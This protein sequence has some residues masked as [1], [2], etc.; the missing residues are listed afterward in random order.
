MKPPKRLRTIIDCATAQGWTYD[1]TSE[2]HPRLT[3]PKG[4]PDPQRPGR[5]MYPVTF[6]K[7]PSDRRGDLNSAAAL[8]RCGVVLPSKDGSTKK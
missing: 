2:G 7:T 6:S 4:M 1:E 8:K 3:P 5:M